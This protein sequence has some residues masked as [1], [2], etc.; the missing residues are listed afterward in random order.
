[1]RRS[2]RSPAYLRSVA[3]QHDIPRHVRFLS[4]VQSAAF[5]E[6]A[7]TWVVTVLDQSSGSVYQIRSRVLI[8]AV[9]A[10]SVPRECEIKGSERFQGRLFHSVRWYDSFDWAGGKLW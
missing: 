3:G 2:L 1:M 7:G 9:G 6:S 8:S 5:D 10:L 4:T